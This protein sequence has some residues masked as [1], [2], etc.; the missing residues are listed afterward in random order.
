MKPEEK[1][2]DPELQ[3]VQTLFCKVIHPLKVD[4][5]ELTYG[6]QFVYVFATKQ[7]LLAP[8]YKNIKKKKVNGIKWKDIRDSIIYSTYEL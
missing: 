5:I 2:Q 4:G 1:T 7:V 6:E 3:G 8:R